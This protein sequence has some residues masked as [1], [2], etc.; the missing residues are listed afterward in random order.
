VR[1]SALLLLLA[2]VSLA[3]PSKKEASLHAKVA[4]VWA[5]HVL[6]CK[7]R[8]L[9]R[10]SFESYELA[11]A[12]N[13]C[14]DKDGSIKSA[15]EALPEESE[16][17]AGAAARRQKA[18]AQAAKIYDK[19]ARLKVERADEYRFAAVRL[20]PSKRRTGRIVK[21]IRAAK[22][23]DDAGRLLTRLQAADPE[24]DYS[25]LE[26]D[27]ARD[28]PVLLR[29][30][31]H[32]IV[33]WLAL[34]KGWKKGRNYPVLV[35]VDGAGSNFLGAARSCSK[36]RGKRPWIVLAPCTLA[37]TNA[38]Q[39]KR[40]PWYDAAL[41]E[42]MGSDNAGRFKFDSEGLLALLD[43]VHERFGGE[44]KFAITGFSGGGF[45]CYGITL[46]HPERVRFAVPACANFAGSGAADAG[47]PND[48]GPP[49][50]IYTG[51]KDPH[52]IWTHGKVGGVPGIE[53]QT[54][55]AVKALQANGFTKVT[56]TK[57]PGVGHSSLY[58]KVWEAVDK[59]GPR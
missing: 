35:V 16:G 59:L 8:K 49:I 37:N 39:P 21:A 17:V 42:K 7:G 20:D 41:L 18:R 54:D 11:R 40:Y 27:L 5:D 44:E 58:P 28:G 19:L 12:L 2:T 25:A 22:T 46:L 36:Q 31:D 47:E 51:E 50:V 24:H 56:R 3:A 9:R 4:Q 6:Y 23:P 32:E 48:G 43:S 45:L 53:A 14:Y 13:P 29:G 30:K 57:L 52:A 55:R 33:G 15:L 38:L 1:R 10:D 34:P 26:V